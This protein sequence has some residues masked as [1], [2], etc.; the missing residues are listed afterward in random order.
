MQTD[1][2]LA[3]APGRAGALCAVI[4]AILAAAPLARADSIWDKRTRSAAFLYTDNAAAEVGDSLTVL[5]ADQSSF[6]MEAERQAEKTTEHSG[7]I[8]IETSLVDLTW[9]PENARQKSSRKFG[10]TSGY[11]A[12]RKLL[13]SITVSVVDKLPNGNLVI[14]G[15][16][17][18]AVSGE[19]VE[20]ILSGIVKPEDISGEN[21][22]ASQR[23]AH[24]KIHYETHGS[25]ES[26]LKEGVL[27]AVLNLLWPF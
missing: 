5:I 9:P 2:Q 20:T 27:N 16:S 4:V 14:A 15:R 1:G 25:S 22:I 10:G 23:V 24:L 13:D 7:E 6:S 8:A 26:Y 21:T 18:R 11:T 19:D 3:R 17:W 12:S